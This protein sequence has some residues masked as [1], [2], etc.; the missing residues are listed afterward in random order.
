[1]QKDRARS[2]GQ[3]IAEV[4]FSALPS[5]LREICRTLKS[6]FARLPFHIFSSAPSP[7]PE[8]YPSCS[9][10]PLSFCGIHLSPE[11]RPL[12]PSSLFC[13]IQ[14]PSAFLDADEATWHA[15]PVA[16][17]RSTRMSL[18]SVRMR[19]LFSGARTKYSFSYAFVVHPSILDFFLPSVIVRSI[20]STVSTSAKVSHV[21]KQADLLFDRSQ[22]W[23]NNSHRGVFAPAANSNIG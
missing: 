13:S 5:P 4:K 14:L 16:R 17:K 22:R 21:R 1:M 7:A 11:N 15:I 9:I 3:R 19:R 18:R 8:H 6:L 10:L 23:E 12:N 2:H 20:L